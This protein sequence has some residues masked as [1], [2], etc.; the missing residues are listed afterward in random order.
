MATDDACLPE[1]IN[2]LLAV[3]ASDLADVRFG[4]LDRAALER[5]AGSVRAAADELADAEAAA[6]AAR[7]ALEAAREEL[8]QKGQRAL[9][10]ARIHA[11]DLPEVSQR[12]QAITLG[13]DLR[14]GEPVALGGHEGAPRRRGRPPKV[15]GE[16]TGTLALGPTAPRHPD[17][18]AASATDSA[19]AIG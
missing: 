16:V 9:A 15:A 7:G 5:G 1:G 4:D 12:L 2:A 18:P 8:L 3:F 17:G 11:E 13:R 19:P 10:H 14:R 6:E